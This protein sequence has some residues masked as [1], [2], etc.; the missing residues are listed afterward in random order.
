MV[1]RVSRALR[2]H[3]SYTYSAA[4]FD[5]AKSRFPAH[6]ELHR[7]RQPSHELIRYMRSWE[8]ELRFDA[9][10]A[11]PRWTPQNRDI[12]IAACIEFRVCYNPNTEWRVDRLNQALAAWRKGLQA[13]AQSS[14]PR[15]TATH[16][17]RAEQIMKLQEK[18]MAADE[19]ARRKKSDDEWN[20]RFGGIWGKFKLGALYLACGLLVLVI[21]C[22]GPLLEFMLMWIMAPR[23]E[24]RQEAMILQKLAY[25]RIAVAVSPFSAVYSDEFYE[26]TAGACS[27]Q[28]G[29]M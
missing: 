7:N 19:M 2:F 29:G 23:V 4:A 1:Y 11:R 13:D 20:A 22:F 5:A 27:L 8:D 16:R 15:W 24:R 28:D 12:M 3:R 26:T 6:W 17:C 18:K 10:D 21:P 14:Q 25:A 9:K